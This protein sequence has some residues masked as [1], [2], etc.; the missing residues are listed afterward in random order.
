M[1]RASVCLRPRTQSH[2][3]HPPSVPGAALRGVP[4]SMES[5]KAALGPWKAGREALVT[6]ED[7][8]VDFTQKEWK[9]LSPAQ[10]TL[11]RHVMLENF[12][13]LESLGIPCSKP[14]LITWLE[15]GEEPWR[16]ERRHRP[17]RCAG[18]LA[19]SITPGS[20]FMGRCSRCRS[21]LELTS[22]GFPSPWRE[23]RQLWNPGRL[24]ERLW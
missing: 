24:A 11:Y 13:H 19:K 22:K 4:F 14:D 3:P 8:A 21:C 10:R 23:G 5:R 7:V 9:L 20:F 15:R 16:E 2:R 17:V 12:S 1:R 18:R 6:F